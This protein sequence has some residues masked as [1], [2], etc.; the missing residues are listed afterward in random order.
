MS[1][2]EKIQGIYGLQHK[3]SKRWYIGKSIDIAKRFKTYKRLSCK[4]QPK[5]Y[6]A[7]VK[8]GV[9]SFDYIIIEIVQLEENL[10]EREKFW[11]KEYK[12]LEE[13]Y[14]LNEGG[15][16]GGPKFWTEE[17]RQKKSNFM[18][19]VVF[20]EKWLAN[21]SKARKGRKL[22][23]EHIEKL[24]NIN[25][26]KV[27]SPE[28]IEKMRAAKRGKKLTEEHKKK[29]G[30]SGTGRKNSEETKEKM[31]QAAF[32]RMERGEKMFGRD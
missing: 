22:S 23:Q 28:T 21:L 32:R 10:A 4:R 27:Y 19:G 24:K 30:L 6:N 5:I 11:I 13:G 9:E 31:R 3:E 26:G 7:L 29:I 8:Y 17:M 15:F 16:G 1:G 12:A 2:P 18:K 14:N 25:T 20:T